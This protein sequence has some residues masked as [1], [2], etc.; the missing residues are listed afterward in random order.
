MSQRWIDVAAGAIV[1]AEKDKVLL[2]RRRADQHQGNLWEFPGGK[3]EAGESADTALI[4]EL[5]EE[6]SITATSLSELIVVEHDYGD[7]AVRLHVFIVNA[8]IGEPTGLEGQTLRWVSVDE[9]HAYRFPD[10][11]VPI[12]SALLKVLND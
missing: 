1:S 10:A 7:K 4:R 5:T 2:A 12:V 8:F 6:I 11:N 9:L 3:I